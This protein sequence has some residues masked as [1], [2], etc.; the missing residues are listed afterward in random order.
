MSEG[1]YS[2]SYFDGRPTEYRISGRSCSFEEF[3]K[4]LE[5]S[6][7]GRNEELIRDIRIKLLEYNEEYITTHE[8]MEW[9][10]ER[11]KEE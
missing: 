4:A 11:I 5:H 8:F 1:F 3:R 6:L 10:R 7:F 2:A 9:L